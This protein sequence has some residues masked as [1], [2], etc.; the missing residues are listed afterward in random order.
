MK[1]FTCFKKTLTSFNLLFLFLLI[2]NTNLTPLSFCTKGRISPYKFEEKEGTCG[3]YSHKNVQGTQ[4]IYKAASN[5]ALFGKTSQCGACYEMVGPNGAIKVRIE[6]YC[7]KEKGS[8]YCSDDM[9]HFNVENN[10][11]SYII[12]NENLANI[13]FRMVSCDYSGNIR[14]FT[15]ENTKDFYLSFVVLDHNLPVSVVQFQESNSIIWNNLTR[16]QTNNNFIYYNLE[17]GIKFPILIRIYSINGDFVDVTMNNAE[18][19][20]YYESV[21][22]FIIP[23]NTYFDISSLKKINVP[24][25]F[26][27]SKCCELD[28]SDFSPIYKDGYIN[29]GYK[30]SQERVSVIYNSNE[31]YLGKYSLK[32][33]FQNFGFLNFISFFPIRA[34]QYQS[35]FFSM[36]STKVCDNC[37]DFGAYG[38]SNYNNFISFTEANIWRNYSFRFDTLGISNNKFNGIFF[39]YNKF[40]TEN[41]EVN[42]ENIQLIPN[43]NAP[44][45]GICYSN[46]NYNNSDNIIDPDIDNNINFSGYN[47][48]TNI[49]IYENNPKILNVKCEPFTNSANKKIILS[50]KSNNSQ[51][52]FDVDNCI[53]PNSNEITSFTCTLPDNIS[54]GFYRINTQSINGLNFTFLKDIE[55]KNGLMIVGNTSSKMNQNSNVNYSPLIIIHSKEQAINKGDNITFNVYPIPQEQY[56]LDD[57]EIILLNNFGDLSL[58]LKSC[59]PNVKNQIVYSVQCKVSNNIIRSNYTHLYSSQITNLLDGQTINLISENSNGGML[60][61]SYNHVILSNLTKAQKRNYSLIFNVLYYNSSVR[62]KDKFPHKVYLVG[63]KKNSAFGHLG[64]LNLYDSYE[65]QIIFKNCTAGEYTTNNA[66][67]SIICLLPD[68]VPAGTYTKLESDG[69]D[70]NPQNSINLTLEKDFNRSAS[71]NPSRNYNNTDYDSSSSSSKKW[72]AWVIVAIVVVFLVAMVII[73]LACK[74]NDSGDSSVVNNTSVSK[75]NNSS[76]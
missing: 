62:P 18:P 57:D 25:N 24:Y 39:N 49:I 73:I 42:I 7:S 40:T 52:N 67:G 13:T 63:E 69:I 38:I 45:A 70:T 75:N 6:D 12:G 43:P 61:S 17:N 3:F 76:V 11:T 1:K 72:I 50:F 54:D 30:I 23:S 19:S 14:I 32:A 56:Y 74:K 44:D 34:D 68:F 65:S 58:H 41:L 53:I 66:I 29:G 33:I 55:I 20:K 71:Y 27:F 8:N 26:N 5:E 21:R 59:K 35:V 60:M 37:L 28:K 16:V 31:N 51:I 4:Y 22:N 47:I 15:D 10:A 9:I 64:N 2:K 46:S 48:I 36:K